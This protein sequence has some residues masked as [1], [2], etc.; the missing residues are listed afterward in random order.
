MPKPTRRF[1][2]IPVTITILGLAWLL[3]TA[4]VGGGIDWFE[5][6][7]LALVA[8]VSWLLGGVSKLTVVVVPWF[9]I[10]S[11]CSL[12]NDAGLLA[13]RFAAPVLVVALGGLLLLA[14]FLDVPR[15]GFML[16]KDPRDDEKG[17]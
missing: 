8:V 5:T 14:L 2:V 9:L 16:D 10:A 12:L 7:I 1:L 3:M 13:E 15:P 4:G 11:V 17:D 6:A